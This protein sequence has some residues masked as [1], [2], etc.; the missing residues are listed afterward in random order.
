M[1]RKKSFNDPK[2]NVQSNTG[3]QQDE[4]IIEF[5][6]IDSDFDK[7]FFKEIQDI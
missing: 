2:R 5:L 6:A 1:K 7:A 3:R 4:T